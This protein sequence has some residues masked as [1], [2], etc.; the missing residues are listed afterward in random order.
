[1]QLCQP[2]LPHQTLLPPQLLHPDIVGA[3]K[4]DVG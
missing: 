2:L 3:Q 1:M 4:Q